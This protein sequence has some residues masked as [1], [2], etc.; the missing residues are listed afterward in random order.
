[1]EKKLNSS[2][3]CVYNIGYH[4]I[5]CPKYRRKVL[6][7]DVEIRLKEIL[8]KVAAEHEWAIASLEV[9]PDHVHVFVKCGPTDSPNHVVSQFKG[10]ASF[11]LRN[12]FRWLKTKLPAL[13]SRSYYC[14]SVGNISEAAIQAYIENQKTR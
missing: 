5:W 4:L 11:E 1:M 12:E 6:T 14:E 2:R 9:M 8:L 10:R 3:G 7:G 13:W